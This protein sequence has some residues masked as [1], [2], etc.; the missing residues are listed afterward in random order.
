M[1]GIVNYVLYIGCMHVILTLTRNGTFTG[2]SIMINLLIQA[3]A[4][5]RMCSMMLMLL[6]SLM[7][8]RLGSVT[9]LYCV[10]RH[11][12]MV[13][14]ILKSSYDQNNGRARK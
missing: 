4:M 6:M 9:L 10:S 13:D 3:G 12:H 5:E 2:E 14:N 8:L 11:R 1:A 7:L